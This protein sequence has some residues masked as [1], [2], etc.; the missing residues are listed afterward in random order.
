MVKIK[1]C[2]FT[3]KQDIEEAIKLGVNLIGL[4]FFPPSPRFVEVKEAKRLFDGLPT[5]ILKVGVFVNPDEKFLFK[6]AKALKIDGIQLHGDEPPWLIKKLKE[7]FEF[8]KFI[9]KTIRVK[10]KDTLQ[11][12][13]RYKPDFFLLDSYDS[14]LFG[15]TG[16]KIDYNNFKEAELPWDKIFLAGGITPENV[17]EMIKRYKPYGIDVASGVE[18][19]LGIKDKEKLKELVQ[20]IK[21]I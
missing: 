6:T 10:D 5:H 4:N 20:N 15:G 2:G 8:E 7:K 18:M 12:M 11:K 3:R 9:I 21:E 17:K 1:I 16:K 19:A 13:S 14:L